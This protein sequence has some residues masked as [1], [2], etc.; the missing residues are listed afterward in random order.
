MT[1][2][3]IAEE[4]TFLRDHEFP[5]MGCTYGGLVRLLDGRL[6]SVYMMIEMTG[7]CGEY[8]M[9][10]TCL[11]VKEVGEDARSLPD[12]NY[13]DCVLM[14]DEEL[15]EEI[16]VGDRITTIGRFVVEEILPYRFVD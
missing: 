11:E 2:R 14:D 7:I 9:A 13:E 3:K 16:I 4:D 10:M 5:I 8:K 6:C 15:E 1:E 12:Y